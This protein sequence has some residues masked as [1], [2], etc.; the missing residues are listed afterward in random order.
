MTIL[1]MAGAVAGC[2]S[3][4]ATLMDSKLDPSLRQMLSSRDERQSADTLLIFGKC[5][6][7]IDAGM[8]GTLRDAGAVVE[9][10]TGDIFTARVVPEAITVLSRLDFIRQLQLSHSS[11]PL[12]K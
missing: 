10:V 11:K 2:G 8:L 6:K 4:K 1:F 9:S 3:E 7:A 5:M 12:P